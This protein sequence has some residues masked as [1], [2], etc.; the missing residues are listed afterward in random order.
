LG[1][2]LYPVAD[3]IA[4]NLYKGYSFNEQTVSELFAIGAPTSQLVVILFTISSM[5]LIAFALGIWLISGNR[6]ILRAL[7]IMVFANAVNSLVLWNFFSMHMRGI[8]P[9]FTDT[10]HGILAINPFVLVSLILGAIYFRN[11]FRYYSIGTIIL[12]ILM[13]VFAVPKAL[14]VYENRPTPG[15]G[16]MERASQYGHQS[17]HAIL[18]I[19][20]LYRYNSKKVKIE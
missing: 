6:G 5:L 16:I 20:L 1:S 8:Q 14:L 10:M 12:L 3:I 19:V 15:L 18:A 11:W 17:W 7:S 4:G 13:V 2:L 9:S